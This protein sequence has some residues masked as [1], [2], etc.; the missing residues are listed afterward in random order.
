MTGPRDPEGVDLGHLL[1][2]ARLTPAQAV[3]L[4]AGVLDG[5]DRGGPAAPVV[6]A[7]GRVLPGPAGGAGRPGEAARPQRAAALLADIAAAAHPAGPAEERL[8]ADVRH[9]GEAL[10]GADAARLRV[11]EAAA[12]ADGPAVRAELAAL[13]RTVRAVPGPAS[14]PVPRSVAGRPA[15]RGGA[16]RAERPAER[17][18]AGRPRATGRRLGAW[19]VSLVVLAAV[20][21]AEVVLLRD[22]IAAD[23][24]LLLDAGRDGTERSS[25]GPSADP[26]VPAAAAPAAGRVAGVDL[27]LL[28]A[29]APGAPCAV[30]VLVRL[31]PG[32]E[33]SVVT[34]SY[35]VLDRCTGAAGTVPGGTVTVAP[36]AGSA[37]AVGTIP[38]PPA[39]GIAVSAV[40]D[41]PAVA[42]SPPVA[43]GSC[44]SGAGPG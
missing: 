30:R 10:P 3:E 24:A 31:V 1:S 23:I 36:Q 28:D 9:A 7:D 17:G 22:D 6:T 44:S 16:A 32:A 27:R 19:L 38:L 5:A 39:A 37:V 25:T 41:A 34:W 18:P 29:C 8:L 26:P 40:T 13:V 35:R 43:V 11:R 15:A 14:R 4:A 20:V 2:L 33:T 12:R 21:A 42:A